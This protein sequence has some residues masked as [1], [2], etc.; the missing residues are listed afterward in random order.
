[1]LQDPWG[2]CSNQEGVPI[3]SLQVNAS[4]RWSPP[5]K[6]LVDCIDQ[7]MRRELIPEQERMDGSLVLVA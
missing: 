5:S 7:R 1:M 4:M 2:T 3:P 6:A